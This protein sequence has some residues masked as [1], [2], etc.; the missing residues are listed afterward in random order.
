M[1]M[2]I[3]LKNLCQKNE[4][5]FLEIDID[6]KSMLDRR[7]LY[8]NFRGQDRVARSIFKHSAQYLN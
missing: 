1:G 6:K 5:V 8:L 2:N 4:I 3:K 7:G